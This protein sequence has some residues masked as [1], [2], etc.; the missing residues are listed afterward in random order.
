MAGFYLIQPGTKLQKIPT[1]IT[2]PLLILAATYN[3]KYARDDVLQ[4]TG[5]VEPLLQWIW[6]AITQGGPILQSLS[7]LNPYDQIY[8]DL[9]KIQEDKL[10]T[11]PP[12]ILH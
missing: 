4:L 2:M 6:G 5:R 9:K 8:A 11:P 7:A 1:I 12:S 10:P 3:L